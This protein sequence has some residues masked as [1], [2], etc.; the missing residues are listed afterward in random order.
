MT[1]SRPLT[2]VVARLVQVPRSRSPVMLPRREGGEGDESEKVNPRIE[3]TQG[4]VQIPWCFCRLVVLVPQTRLPLPEGSPGWL[5]QRAQ[6]QHAEHYRRE[7]DRR[8]RERREGAYHSFQSIGSSPMAG[9][10]EPIRS[11]ARRLP[12]P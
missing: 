8:S 2:R 9:R 3:L 10:G 12:E 1:I 4:L 7:P 11:R 5:D 6:Q